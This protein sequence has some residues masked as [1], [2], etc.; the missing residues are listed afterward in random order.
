MRKGKVYE[1]SSFNY[2]WRHIEPRESLRS[3]TDLTVT[4]IYI[5]RKI[6]VDIIE[7]YFHVYENKLQNMCYVVLFVQKLFNIVQY[8]SQVFEEKLIYELINKFFKL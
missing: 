7:Y 2:A 8:N 1:W 4:T 5:F 6:Y 3:S